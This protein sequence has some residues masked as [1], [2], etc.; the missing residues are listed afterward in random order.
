MTTYDDADDMW[1][2]LL[3]DL[4]SGGRLEAHTDSRDGDVCA[5]LLGWSAV[6]RAGGQRT[7]VTCPAREVDPA[8][9]AA[10]AL[11]YL[12]G[13]DDVG[14]IER[15]APSYR[16]RYADAGGTSGAG[17]GKRIM[18]GLP[19]ALEALRARRETRQAY[20]DVWGRGDLIAAERPSLRKNVPCTLGWQLLARGGELHLSHV[21][22]SN[23][24]WLGFPYDVFSA[25]CFQR[26]VAAELGLGVGLYRHHVVG[27]VHL[28]RRHEAG[29]AAALGEPARGMRPGHGWGLDDDLES[30]SRAVAAEAALR[31]SCPSRNGVDT[32]GIGSMMSDLFAL[33]HNKLK[34][35]G[36]KWHV[37]SERMRSL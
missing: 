30:A 1:R 37:A 16:E 12:S 17:Y 2:G 15:Y 25:C 22:R 28:Y 8:Y 34:L 35:D 32:A 9:A 19:L 18:S 10:E 6:L 27:S 20:V 14:M 13:T 21:L 5:E 3:S 11:W 33:C 36:P 4:L 24:A 29:A 31:T 23:D 26:L 7:L